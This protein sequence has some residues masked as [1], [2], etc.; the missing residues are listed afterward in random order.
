MPASTQDVIPEQG[1]IV[2]VWQRQ[3]VVTNVLLSALPPGTEQPWTRHSTVTLSAIEDDAV[4][5]SVQVIWEVEPGADCRAGRV[6]GA[7]GVRP[8]GPVDAFLHAVRWGDRL[9]GRAA[10]Q[11]PFRSGIDIED[12]QLDPLVRAVQDAAGQPVDR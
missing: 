11:A 2:T 8:A 5:E 4:G 9:G 12:Y 1:Q 6:A 3:Y 10:L 7:N